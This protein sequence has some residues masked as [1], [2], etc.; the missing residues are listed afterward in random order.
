M[1]FAHAVCAPLSLANTTV[2]MT[3][4]PIPRSVP[5]SILPAFTTDNPQLKKQYIAESVLQSHPWLPTSK[6][7]LENLL[8]R[9]LFLYRRVVCSGDEELAKDQLRSQLR[10]KVVVDRET[11]WS[12][13]VSGHRGGQQG[14]FRSVE[15]DDAAFDLKDAR[16]SSGW[17]GLIGMKG[18]IFMFALGVLAAVVVLYYTLGYRGEF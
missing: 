4:T 9:I 14:I 1:I 7:S 8:T 3:R 16:E 15:Q 18:M 13:M 5:Y 11:V 17:R 10:E 12:Q 6:T 2:D